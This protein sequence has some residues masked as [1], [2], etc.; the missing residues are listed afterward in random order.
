MYRG[1]HC[2]LAIHFE[3][4]LSSFVL[5]VFLWVLSIIKWSKLA[6]YLHNTNVWGNLLYKFG[7][8]TTGV[9]IYRVNPYCLAINSEAIPSS[10]VLN[11]FLSYFALSNGPYSHV[12]CIA[13]LFGVIFGQNLGI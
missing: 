7:Y 5:N 10:V 4:I 13:L 9:T 3:E 12:I 11:V 2:C 1:T 8:L 6:S